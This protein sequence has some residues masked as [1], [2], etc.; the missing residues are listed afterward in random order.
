MAAGSSQ[1]GGESSGQPVEHCDQPEEQSA[2]DHGRMDQMI[3]NENKI[4]DKNTNNSQ[5]TEVFQ[6]HKP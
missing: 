6:L 2:L 1:C 4:L 3:N 5:N